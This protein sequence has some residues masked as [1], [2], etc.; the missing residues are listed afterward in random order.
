MKICVIFDR[1]RGIKGVF[2]RRHLGWFVERGEAVH[3]Y[4]MQ[5]ATENLYNEA[6]KSG[7]KKDN[8]RDDF[9]RRL[10]NNKIA[11][12]HREITNVEEIKQKAYDFF[13]KS[14]ED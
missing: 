3:R 7:K 1:H 5:H 4:C 10:S 9:R 8:L 6:E 11:S 2:Q 14:E 13:K 12:F